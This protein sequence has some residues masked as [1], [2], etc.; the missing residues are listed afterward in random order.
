VLY[1]ERRCRHS[2]ELADGGVEVAFVLRD[3]DTN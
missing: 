1:N 2:D 3:R